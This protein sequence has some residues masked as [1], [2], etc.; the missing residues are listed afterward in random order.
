MQNSDEL[1]ADILEVLQLNQ[2]ALG[3]AIEEISLWVR[4]RGE[5]GVHA[6]VMGTLKTLDQSS[7]A[8]AV[9]IKSLRREGF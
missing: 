6:N 5:P 3:A 9:A 2:N 7:G 4:S 8:I 1:I